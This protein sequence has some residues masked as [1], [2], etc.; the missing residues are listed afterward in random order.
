ML[1]AIRRYR[2]RKIMAKITAMATESTET[3]ESTESWWA[4]WDEL[5]AQLAKV[6]K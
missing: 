1:E 2:Q 5:H 4:R 3:N 6:T